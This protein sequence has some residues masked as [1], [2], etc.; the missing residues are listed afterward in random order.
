M[1]TTIKE[2]VLAAASMTGN[3]AILAVAV[4]CFLSLPWLS[5]RSRPHRILYFTF[6]AAR[7]ANS[8]TLQ[9]PNPPIS[10]LSSRYLQW[11]P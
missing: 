10:V 9:S 4:T 2:M 11:A 1:K 7:L 3:A 6:G 8:P 5:T